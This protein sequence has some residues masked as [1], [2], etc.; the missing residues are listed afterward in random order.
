MRFSGWEAL[1]PRPGSPPRL[2]RRLGSGLVRFS[3]SSRRWE[4][5]NRRL[6]GGIPYAALGAVPPTFARAC[7]KIRKPTMDDDVMQAKLLS[8]CAR[9]DMGYES[10]CLLW[11]RGNDNG[12]GKMKVTGW[13][14]RPDRHASPKPFPVG[15]SSNP[16]PRDSGAEYLKGQRNL[17]QAKAFQRGP[18]KSPLRHA[19]ANASQGRLS[20]PCQRQRE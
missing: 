5:C 17:P 15:G 20:R 4:R 14:S 8:G 10:P 2:R 3:G 9:K 19:G 1:L 13:R 16:R 7:S 6:C 18:K 12:Y 11:T